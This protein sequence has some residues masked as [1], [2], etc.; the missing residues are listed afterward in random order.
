LLL[1]PY[2]VDG[3]AQKVVRCSALLCYLM[4]AFELLLLRQTLLRIQLFK[5]HLEMLGN[6]L[7]NLSDWCLYD[8][9]MHTG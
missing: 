5:F 7:M 8:S 6:F 1:E 2:G 3:V 9:E 4:V